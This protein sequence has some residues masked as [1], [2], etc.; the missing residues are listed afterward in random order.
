[1]WQLVPGQDL[2]T[3]VANY[4]N[5]SDSGE[6]ELPDPETESAGREGQEETTDPAHSTAT[7]HSQDSHETE[8]AGW[9]DKF[10]DP[11]CPCV[12]LGLFNVSGSHT[13]Q[14]NDTSYICL[15]T[16]MADMICGFYGTDLVEFSG[17]LVEGLYLGVAEEGL[18][19]MGVLGIGL[20]ANEASNHESKRYHNLPMQLKSSGLVDKFT[21]CISTK[22]ETA[23]SRAPFFLGPWTT[24]STGACC[25]PCQ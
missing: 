21:P 24:P 6:A 11:L 20:P 8:T 2:T 10:A 25:R 19:S 23:P 18:I 3:V 17:A 5:G 16:Y 9:F 13:F 4:R 7:A 14:G 12:Q 15:M 22:T 1:M